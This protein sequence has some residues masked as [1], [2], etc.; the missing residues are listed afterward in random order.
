MGRGIST[1]EGVEKLAG[2]KGDECSTK[3]GRKETRGRKKKSRGGKLH[4]KSGLRGQCGG[5]RRGGRGKIYPFADDFPK[6]SLSARRRSMIGFHGETILI[7]N[8]VPRRNVGN[9]IGVH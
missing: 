2:G 8:P 1:M 3:R 5:R 7:L 6:K 9:S 4:R